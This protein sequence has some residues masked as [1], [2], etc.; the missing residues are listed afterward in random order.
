MYILKYVIRNIVIN[1]F[2]S[3]RDEIRSQSFNIT[4]TFDGL[5]MSKLIRIFIL[6]CLIKNRNAL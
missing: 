3:S 1:I 4:I 5:H 2:K 6:T